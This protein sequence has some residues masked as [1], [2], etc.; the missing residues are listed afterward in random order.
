MTI[1]EEGGWEQPPLVAETEEVGFE[2]IW[3]YILK[4]KNMVA[5]YIATR[6]ITDLCKK[7][8]RRPGP[9]LLRD[10]GNRRG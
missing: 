10:G 5:Q 2:E 6:P 4:R 7:M 1:W 3:A 9:G 8:V